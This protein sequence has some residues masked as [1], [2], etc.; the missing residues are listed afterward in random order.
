MFLQHQP[1]SFRAA[2]AHDAGGGQKI[3][4]LFL[5]FLLTCPILIYYVLAM[6]TTITTPND[7]PETAREFLARL[8]RELPLLC[9]PHDLV[10]VGLFKD[11]VEVTE[12]RRRGQGPDYIQYGPQSFRYTR[13]AVLSWFRERA[14]PQPQEEAA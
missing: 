9:T 14:K 13:E 1:A 8:E 3:N 2:C 12:I 10:A 6:E 11:R 4:L 7:V 5:L